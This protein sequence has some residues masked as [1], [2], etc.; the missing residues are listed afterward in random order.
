MNTRLR[1]LSQT[2]MP[3]DLAGVALPERNVDRFGRTIDYMRISIT[4]RC[5]LRC[6]YCMP[7]EGVALQPKD[8][9]LTFEETTRVAASA[10][11]LGFRKFRI[12]G[13]EPL[14]VRDVLTL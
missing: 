3:A 6:I 7:E 9:L 5:N 11:R 1:V 8:D 12:T 13:G 10:R 14:V 2:V 4:D